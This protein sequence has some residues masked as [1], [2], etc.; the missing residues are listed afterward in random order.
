[1][2]WEGAVSRGARDG[3]L[4]CEAL[5][6]THKEPCRLSA[7]IYKMNVSEQVAERLLSLLLCID[8]CSCSFVSVLG[9]PFNNG[10]R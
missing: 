6:K 9:Q 8:F 1:M 4:A 3:D 10:D 2:R 7:L 5:A